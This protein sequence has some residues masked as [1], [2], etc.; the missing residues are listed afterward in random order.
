[1]GEI[2]A[3][4]ALNLRTSNMKG[5]TVSN[6]VATCGE[7][8]TTDRRYRDAVLPH[9]TPNRSECH[10]SLNVTV[11]GLNFANMAQVVAFSTPPFLLQ[12]RMIVGTALCCLTI[13]QPQ[14]PASK[15]SHA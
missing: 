2:Y 6:T 13:S 4:A 3:P 12:D 1:M 9:M 15:V 10:T 11:S 14:T 7:L 5:Y 8:L